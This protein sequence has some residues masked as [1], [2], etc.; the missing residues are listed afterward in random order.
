MSA[1]PP[2]PLWAVVPVKRFTRAKSRLAGALD[3]AARAALARRLADHVLDVLAAGTVDAALVVTDGADA[4]EWAAARGVAVVDDGPARG[5]PLGAIVDVGLAAAAARGG[6]AAIV[7]MSDLPRLVPDDVRAL[8]SAL[9]P[10]R[11]VLAPD[12]QGTGTNA[13]GLAL[14]A[15][16]PSC[17]GR[18]DSA[19][20]HRALAE[21]HGLTLTVLD[22]GGLSDDLDDPAD[23]ARPGP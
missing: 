10:G 2:R 11:L 14:P 13:L 21:R 20:G 3:P 15:A 8:A 6:R 23:L 17:F 12:H 4:A 5:G 1:S 16:A 18:A 19:A 22:R 9:A 7:L